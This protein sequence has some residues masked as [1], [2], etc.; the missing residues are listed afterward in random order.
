MQNASIQQI[1]SVL[2]AANVRYL[3]AGGLAV[4]AHGH[5]RFTADVDLALALESENLK[6]ALAALNEIGYCPRLPVKADEFA[7]PQRRE[8]WIREKN[9]KVFSLIS[10]QHRKTPIDLFAALPFDFK[11]E[12]ARAV[13]IDIGDGLRAPFVSLDQLIAM[14]EKAGRP[15]DLL[16]V[17]VLK[18]IRALKAREGADH[19]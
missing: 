19:G 12:Y 10:G 8:Q 13:W 7:D 2:N 18:N 1:I 9:M 5:L 14:K 17:D 4:V 6:R 11:A 15:Q 16:D 3:I